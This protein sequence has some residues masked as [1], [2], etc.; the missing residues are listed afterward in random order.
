MAANDE[1]K[2]SIRLT[3]IN[4]SLKNK[5][6][7]YFVLSAIIL[8]TTSLIIF[9]EKKGLISII[10]L[11]AS[12]VFIV[13]LIL[14]WE[15]LDKSNYIELKPSGILLHD[16]EQDIFYWVEN[17]SNVKLEYVSIE[18]RFNLFRGSLDS[19]G[20]NTLTFNYLNNSVQL[21]FFL[22]N[23]QQPNKIDFCMKQ[24]E[25][26]GIIVKVKY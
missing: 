9:P 2:E 3:L 25:R 8:L 20:G 26:K 19:G 12:G 15:K 21:N 23:H 6:P 1:K 13:W 17:I 7:F 11:A 22:E 14:T 18:G 10:T 5:I 16:N 4:K 24:W